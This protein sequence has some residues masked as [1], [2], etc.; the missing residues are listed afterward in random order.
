[1]GALG[2]RMEEQVI[3]KYDC[4]KAP[5]GKKSVLAEFGKW[6]DKENLEVR[7]GSAYM[8][9]NCWLFDVDHLPKS[10]PTHITVED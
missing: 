2:H 4:L 1:M 10:L 8:E 5:G 6:A 9:V 7:A 3:L